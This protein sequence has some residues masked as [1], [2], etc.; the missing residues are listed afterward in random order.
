VFS[1]LNDMNQSRI[2]WDC[3][4]GGG[5][6]LVSDSL[7]FERGDPQPSD[8]HL[9]HIYGL[10]L[11]LL[12]RGIPVTPVQLENSTIAHYLDGFRVLLLTY[13]GMK[14]LSPEVHA[15][16]ADWVKAGGALVVC[17]DDS[18]A[19]NQVKEW[20]NSD[21]LSYATPREHLFEKL[22]LKGNTPPKFG[23]L[24]PVGKGFL[25][26]LRDNPVNYAANMRDEDRLIDAVKT[27][28]A[29]IGVKWRE[30][31]YLSLRRGPYLVAAGLDESIAGD[32]KELKGRFVN[33]FD[34]E[35]RV[36]NRISLLPGSRYL[37]LDLEAGHGPA[38]KV[39]ASAC[40]VIPGK[41]D[42]ESFSMAV[43][44]IVDT[45]GIILVNT[46]KAP[47]TVTLAGNPVETVEFSAGDKLLWIRFPNEPRQRELVVNF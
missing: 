5:G 14:P 12:K 40:K 7:M 45:S 42:K 43:E 13:Q 17:D 28:A 36:Q 8:P 23:E 9:S 39:L 46:E 38:P 24:H 19:F 37:L 41:Q 34:A 27:A 35:L 18:D 6:V 21:S 11:P 4:T 10:A 25:F 22:G 29:K 16:L 3:G 15:A 20:W 47:R 26:S 33:L 1:A 30:S 44:G 2:E 32:A 31:N